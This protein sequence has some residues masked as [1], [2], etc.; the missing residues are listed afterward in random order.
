MPRFGGIGRFNFA[1]A[2]NM[3]FSALCDVFTM[4]AV[5]HAK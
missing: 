5:K 2:P 3:H 1:A 4:Q